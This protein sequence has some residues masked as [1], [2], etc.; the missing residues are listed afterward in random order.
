[1]KRIL[2]ISLISLAAVSLFAQDEW[3]AL[4]Y[5]RIYYNGTSRFTSVAGSFGAVGADLS[6]LATNPAG[7]GLYRSFEFSMTPGVI[8]NDASTTYNGGT[9]DD[10]KAT[11]AFTNVGFVYTIATGKAKSNSGLRNINFGFALNR[12]NDFNG[13]VFI[14]GPNYTS[15]LLNVY[16]DELN[17]A[18]VPANQI[19]NTYPF[20]VGLAYDCGLVYYDSLQKTYRTDMPYGGVYQQA[21]I[22]TD[23]SMNEYDIS[24]GGNIA[25]KLYFGLTVGVPAIRY[26][27]TTTYDE[28][29]SGDTIPYFQEMIYQY[30]FNTHAIGIN[31]KAGVIYRP[32]DWVRIGAAVHTPTW[33][34]N[35]NDSWSSVMYAYY[36]SALTSPPQYSPVG[37]YDYNLTTPFRA[38]GSVAFFIGQRGFISG[39]YEYSNPNQARYKTDDHS[40]DGVNNSIQN[41]FK[42]PV[43]FR[44]GTEWRFGA[45]RVRGGFGYNGSPVK[46]GDVGPRYTA[47]GGAGYFTK[48]FFVD[49]AYQWM[50]MKSNYYLYESAMNNPA[51][52]RQNIHTAI[53]T[54]G[55]RF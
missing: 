38:I 49:L 10:A 6:V 16:A 32:A 46:S 11:F 13:T 12:Q 27:Q 25:N 1:M 31:V 45:F 37:Y 14:Q 50:G 19:R 40:F 42:A 23:G 41:D 53:T 8:I 18:Q 2:L 33:Y 54:I 20:D 28:Y 43:I 5:S 36:D 48:H 34:T 35:M 52:I 7:I 55:V 47:S 22:E 9:G 21:Y 17:R 3:D 30:G 51:E 44:L 15:S 26:Y 29:D 39:E 4:R 24:T